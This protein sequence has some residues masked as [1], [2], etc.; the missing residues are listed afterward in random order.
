MAYDADLA[1]RMRDL[2][3][4]TPGLSEKAMFGG[5]A[6]MVGGN[7]AVGAVGDG[8]IVR[9]EPDRYEEMLDEPG[10][11]L[12]DFTGRPMRGWVSVA[13]DAV[14]TDESLQAWIDRGTGYAASLP[15]KAPG[16]GR[17]TRR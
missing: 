15:A 7:M 10:A 1:E 4:G 11:G 12:M 6:F 17:R 3:A 5:I 16:S 8:L 13:A 2:L 14:G 9:V